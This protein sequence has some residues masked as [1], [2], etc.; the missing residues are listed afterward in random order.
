MAIF[1]KL[2]IL[3]LLL[4]LFVSAVRADQVSDLQDKINKL[5]EQISSAQD[6]EKTL[7][8]QIVYMDNQIQ[9]TVS[10]IALAEEKLTRLQKSIAEV[11]EKI[12]RLEEALTKTSE[13]LSNRISTTYKTG[14]Q[15]PMMNLFFSTDLMNFTSR[16]SYLR[17]VQE[18]DRELLEQMALA[19]Q[20]YHGQ[21]TE[22]TDIKKEQEDLKAQLKSYQATLNSQK[23]A[24]QILLE[25][26]RNDEKRY[27][28]MLAQ[29][30]AEYEAILAITAGYGNETEV[31]SVSEG[32]RIADVIPGPSACSTGAHLHFEIKKGSQTENPASYLSSKS[33]QWGNSPDGPFSFG[34]NWSWPVEDPVTITQGYGMTYYA[35][36]YKYYGG[37]P[38]SGV[39][40]VNTGNL[41]VKA[42]KNGTLYRGSISC[43]GGILKYVK[44]KQ[45]D[46]IS[47]FYLHVNY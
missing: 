5:Q 39:D 7:S 8:G 16:L 32:N 45:S 9:L 21:K 41:K 30:R 17:R 35:S 14:R 42:V 13:I 25:T 1:K 4:T 47:V 28:Q 15:D 46:D 37:A 31:G 10:R 29:A 6:Q 33:V 36:T 40:M 2:I 12:S 24:K 19:R 20:N 3:G 38:H 22:L 26:T 11:T 18:H 34:G 23:K 27:Q 43:G 44:V